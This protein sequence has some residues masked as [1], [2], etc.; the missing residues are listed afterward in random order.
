[1]H[2]RFGPVALLCAALG[3][4]LG[5][6]LA[7]AA[8]GA[9]PPPAHPPCAARATT[10]AGRNAIVY[11]GPASVVID[12]GGRT[13]R[14][15]HGLCDRSA[16]LGALELNAGTLVA[17]APGNLGRSFVS[18]VIAQSPSWS[19]AFEADAGGQQLF[20]E[21][22]IVTGGTLLGRGT[23]TGVLGASFSGS[24]DCHGVIYH[25]P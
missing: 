15:R 19:E 13:Y 16:T 22:A 18:I 3:A 5:G 6:G 8:G 14:F 21:S 12:I 11:C 20:G 4:A 2:T 10:I 17:G 23:F 1:V 7:T 9:A 25:G 24:W